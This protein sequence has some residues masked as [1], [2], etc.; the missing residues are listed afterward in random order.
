MTRDPERIPAMCQMILDL[1]MFHPEWDLVIL[2][3]EVAATAEGYDDDKLE[4]GLLR[5]LEM[6]YYEGADE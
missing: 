5:W 1:W 6:A 2:L 4:E 3:K